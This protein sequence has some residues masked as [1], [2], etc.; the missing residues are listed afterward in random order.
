MG[1]FPQ[2]MC[3]FFWHFIRIANRNNFVEEFFSIRAL[4]RREN[5]ICKFKN[6]GRSF[7]AP[8][9]EGTGNVVVKN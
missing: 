3:L 6:N 7:F 9:T 8:K 5:S 4:F 2:K 1:L